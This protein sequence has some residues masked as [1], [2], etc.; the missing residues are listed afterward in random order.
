MTY[1]SRCRGLSWAIL[2]SL[3]QELGLPSSGVSTGLGHPSRLPHVAASGCGLWLGAQQRGRAGTPHSPPCGP[4]VSLGLLTP[5][6]LGAMNGTQ[7]MLLTLHSVGQSKSW[8]QQFKGR[9]ADSISQCRVSKNWQP[10]VTFHTDGSVAVNAGRNP[11][12]DFECGGAKVQHALEHIS[13]EK[14]KV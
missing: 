13:K 10:P 7:T 1:L 8:G 2:F 12:G 5:Q 6:G 3:W 9:E 11:Q 4:S 14:K